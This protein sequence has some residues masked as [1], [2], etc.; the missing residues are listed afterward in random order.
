M[1]AGLRRQTIDSDLKLDP[2][3]AGVFEAIAQIKESM[4]ISNELAS[5]DDFLP[6]LPG[7]RERSELIGRGG[8]VEF[9][10]YDYYG[11][12]LSKLLRGHEKDLRDVADLVGLGRIEVTK[13]LAL[14]HEIEKELIRY[15]GIV[16]SD[17]KSR[18]ET[19]VF[20]HRADS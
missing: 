9:Y 16:A 12:A 15:P 19:F 20:E 3:P 1:L 7:W 10:V 5:P 13:L 4:A 11:L 17:F 18:V 8:Q 6:P 2:E 14:F